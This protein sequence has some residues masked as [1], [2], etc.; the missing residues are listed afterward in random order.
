[1]VRASSWGGLKRLLPTVSDT[2]MSFTA[3]LGDWRRGA[4][5]PLPSVKGEGESWKERDNYHHGQERGPPKWVQVL[6]LLII[7][8]ILG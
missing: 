5:S 6:D 2:A 3:V 8:V 4:Q 7:C 1:M